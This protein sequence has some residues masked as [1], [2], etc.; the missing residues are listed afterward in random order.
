VWGIVGVFALGLGS[1]MGL[2][3]MLKQMFN[4]NIGLVIA[5]SL[6]ILLFMLVIEAVFI[7]LI[8]T[9]RTPAESG[10]DNSQAEG[11]GD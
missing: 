11:P 9:H 8:F 5:F 7:A 10:D 3:A 6:T 1:I 2:M 4:A